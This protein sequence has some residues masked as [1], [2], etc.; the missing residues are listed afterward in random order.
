MKTGGMTRKKTVAD[1]PML[2]A[3]W[4]PTRNADTGPGQVR[5][6]H[7]RKVW[8][9]CSNGPDHEWQSTP[10]NMIKSQTWQS[11][12]G[13]CPFCAG[14]KVSV[15]NSLATRNPKAAA[16]WH[17]TK[18]GELTPDRV[19]AG[20]YRKVWWK[21]PN[22]PDHEWLAAIYSI[23]TRH[24]SGCPF[25]HGWRLSVTNSLATRFPEVAAQWHPTK[26]GDPTPDRVVAGSRRK[27]WWKCP[28]G[29]DHE[30]QT[31]I[32]SRTN[33]SLPGLCPCCSGY[34]VSVTNSLVTRFP[35]VAAEWHPTKN[36]DLTPDRVTT[37]T[38]RKVWWIC[39]NEPDHE[40]QATI[41]NRTS[42]ESK[43]PFCTLKPRSRIEILLAFELALFLD[44][45]I[46]QH[47][48]KLDGT[49]F[50]VDILIP[51]RQLVVEFDGFFWHR[52]KRD[53]DR[54]KTERLHGNGWTV[55]RVREQ[56]L[57]AVGPYDVVVRSN[58]DPKQCANLVL[59]RIEEVC[60]ISLPGLPRYLKRK[61]LMNSKAAEAYIEE[62]LRESA[63]A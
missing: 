27:V 6:G 60:N 32:N 7:R 30:W 29:P 15:T 23:T 11:K 51:D 3:Q 1:F 40:W 5:Y 36:G 34:K 9:K 43:C 38:Q 57:D 44:F 59:R 45:D 56:P 17:P 24:T 37:G 52:D 22:G 31:S 16:R 25:C 61:R 39:P 26:N 55:I 13:G 42:R 47:K 8:W 19:V 35:E 2:A 4:H 48:L 49:V 14:K 63:S 46:R 10:N 12:A 54:G 18:N 20:S 21:C 58:L 50:D 28:A 41:N 33:P 53:Q 62:L